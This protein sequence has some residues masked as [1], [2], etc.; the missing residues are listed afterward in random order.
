[1]RQLVLIISVA[2][3]F[4]IM[5]PFAHLSLENQ[6]DSYLHYRENYSHNLK[7]SLLQRYR[8]LSC[9]P[10]KEMEKRENKQK[11]EKWNFSH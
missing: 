11:E 2:G 9:D 6:N 8:K 3:F 5:I 10:S 1:M 4:I 7:N